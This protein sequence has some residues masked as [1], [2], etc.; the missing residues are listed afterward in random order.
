VLTENFFSHVVGKSFEEFSIDSSIRDVDLFSVNHDR[1][2]FGGLSFGSWSRFV[3][4]H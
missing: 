4:L 1:Y 2:S 3:L